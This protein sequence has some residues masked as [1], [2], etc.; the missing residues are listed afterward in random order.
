M[1]KHNKR[2]LC[3]AFGG[4]LL[5]WFRSSCPIRL[6]GHCNQYNTAQLLW[7]INFFHWWNISLLTGIVSSMLPSNGTRGVTVW[8]D[9]YDNDVNHQH[10]CEILDPRQNTKWCQ[11]SGRVSET[12]SSDA[13]SRLICVISHLS[14]LC[15]LDFSL[16]F[17]VLFSC[18]EILES[19]PSS[20]RPDTPTQAPPPP[21]PSHLYVALIQTQAISDKLLCRDRWS[22]L[23]TVS[24][25]HVINTTRSCCDLHAYTQYDHKGTLWEVCLKTD[26]GC[27]LS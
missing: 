27:P 4:I 5:A 25:F 9:E 3:Y 8:F 13:L 21:P 20:Y 18:V 23:S 1:K 6:K 12:L 26:V 2:W 17:G 14:C 22:L 7:V 19:L 16:V 15:F 11:T 10:I 24:K